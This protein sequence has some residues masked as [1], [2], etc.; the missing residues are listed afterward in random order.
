[1]ED[2]PT[3]RPVNLIE[4][5]E[6]RRLFQK[7]GEAYT[8]PVPFEQSLHDYIESF[9]ARSSLSRDHMTCEMATAF[10]EEVKELVSPFTE[11]GKIPLQVRGH[12]TWGKPLG[13]PPSQE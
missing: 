6:K 7:E 1:M 11:Q 8:T 10:D 3:Y 5:L 12:I 13:A 9:H 2:N 4:E